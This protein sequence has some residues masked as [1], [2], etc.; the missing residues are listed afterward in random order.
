MRID[1][2]LLVCTGNICRSPMAQG[3]LAGR[4]TDDIEV[5]SAGVAAVVGA[6]ASAPAQALM[7]ARGIDISGHRGRQL[8]LRVATSHDLLLVMEN[9]HRD[10]IL[11]CF[12]MTRG[13]VHLLGAW[14]DELEIPDPYRRSAAVYEQALSMMEGCV[15]DWCA[16]IG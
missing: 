13:R 9:H 1:S 4:L 10:W 16:R 8:D 7:K 5:A 15:A 12:P 11:S 6:P 2:V 14:R 3:L